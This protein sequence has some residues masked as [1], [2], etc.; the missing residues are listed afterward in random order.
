MHALV[1]MKLD[2]WVVGSVMN[3]CSFPFTQKNV[4]LSSLHYHVRDFCPPD[5]SLQV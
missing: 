3:M 2:S 4:K 5:A 1:V